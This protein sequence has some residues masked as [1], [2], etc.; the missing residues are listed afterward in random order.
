MHFLISIHPTDIGLD[1]FNTDDSTEHIKEDNA[2]E[3]ESILETWKMGS[4][5]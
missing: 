3:V 2:S 1:I 4:K 5:F